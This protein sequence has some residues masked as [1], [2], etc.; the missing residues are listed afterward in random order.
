MR[1]WT[2]MRGDIKGGALGWL[3]TRLAALACVTLIIGMMATAVAGQQRG[4]GAAR[5]SA[6]A[7]RG[8]DGRVTFGAP[9]GETGVWERRNEH[10]VINPDSYQAAA[11]KT[12]RVHIKDVPLQPW[13]RALTNYRHSLSLASEPYARCKASGGPRQ[14]MS[15]YGLEIVDRPELQR[16]YIFNISNA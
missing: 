12:A 13:A 15:P 9:Q 3:A 8:A 5:P 14:L 2:A 10:L 1:R 16:I 11:T 7:P 4:Q 6:P